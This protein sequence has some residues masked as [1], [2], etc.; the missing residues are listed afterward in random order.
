MIKNIIKNF[1]GDSGTNNLI[2]RQLWVKDKL[3]SLPTGS[4]I[5]DAGAG[6]CQ[7]KQY[8]THLNYVSQDF[9]QYNGEG[10]GSGIQTGNWDTSSIDIV[11]DI[12]SIPEP[13]ESFDSI[14]CTEVFEHIP[15][16]ILA[17]KEFH[18]LLKFNAEIIITA[19]FC[20][21]TH[22]APYH[23]YSGFNKYFYEY[24]L[25]KIGYKIIEISLNGDYSEYLAQEIRR[26]ETI[27]D[28]APLY[29]RFC[30]AILLRFIKVNRQLKDTSELCCFGFHIRAIKI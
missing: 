3:L 16:P 1:I 12:T 22:F 27:Y 26:L 24:H 7:Y 30:I 5:L 21:L 13:D 17:L 6:E 25:N 29:I 2:I 19:P 9:N 4:R 18:R 20:S 8:C 28:K 10:N 11:S 15:D 23:Y 14:L